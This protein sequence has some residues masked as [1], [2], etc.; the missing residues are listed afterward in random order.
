[1]LK[2]EIN[3][4]RQSETYCRRFPIF[5]ATPPFLLPTP[6]ETGSGCVIQAF[7]D[8]ELH[9]E[10]DEFPGDLRLFLRERTKLMLKLDTVTRLLK[11]I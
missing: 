10:L 1:M 5:P 6:F 2:L 11:N 3:L 7:L 8:G 4:D 9:D